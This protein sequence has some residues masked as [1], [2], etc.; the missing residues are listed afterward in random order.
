[1]MRRRAVVALALS[2]SAAAAVAIAAEQRTFRSAV[3]LVRVDALVTDGRHAITGLTAADFELR[4]NG[5]PQKIDSVSLESLPLSV[6]FVLDTSGS[7]GGMKLAHLED[8]VE[9]VLDRLHDED[10][11]SLITFSHRVHL[12]K[13]LTANRSAIRD[14]VHASSSGGATA[15]RDA[16]YAGLALNAGEH[17]RPL[18]IAFSDG[19]DNAS[20]LTDAVVQHAAERSNAVVYGVAVAE[21]IVNRQAAYARGQ[22][23]FLDAIAAA[24]GGRVI[25]ADTTDRVAAAFGD[26]LDE[27]RTRYFLTYYPAGGA[28]TPGWH[29][30]AVTVK[31]RRATVTARPGYQR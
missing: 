1:M 13:P 4:D 11:A 16:V 31:G 10:L 29:A 7:V 19:L 22:T 28:A 17:A 20:W 26:V 24:T 8:A 15:L 6:T 2:A 14:A 3:D 23:A 12:A 5:V 9:L 18:L 27:F 30:I 21:R 25:R